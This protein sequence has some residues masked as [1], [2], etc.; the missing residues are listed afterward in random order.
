MNLIKITL[1]GM[2]TYKCLKLV[3]FSIKLVFGTILYLLVVETDKVISILN[4]LQ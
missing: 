2:H 4:S 3:V 1:K